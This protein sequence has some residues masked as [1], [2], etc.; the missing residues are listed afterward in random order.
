MKTYPHPSKASRELVCTAGVTPAGE[1]RRLYPVDFRYRPPDQRYK[2]YQWIEVDVAN[3]DP[4]GDNRKESRIPDL[5]S[6]TLHEKLPAG[7]WEKRRQIV[8]CLPTHTLEELKYAYKTNRTSL[9]IATPCEVL[10]LETSPCEREWKPQWRQLFLQVSLFGESPKAL[11]KVPY[12][13]KYVFRCANSEA[14]HRRAILDWELGALFWK[15]VQRLG[16]EEAAR[17][18]VK[19]KFLDQMCSRGRETKFFMGTIHPFNTWAVLGVYW[20]P[21]L[22]SQRAASVNRMSTA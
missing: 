11:R 9:G 3:R 4:T 5:S 12:S 7:S 15:E 20:P 1:W 18:S 14:V 8:D 2:K 21:I 16:T 17:K 6:I 19:N 22:G 10:D 13:F